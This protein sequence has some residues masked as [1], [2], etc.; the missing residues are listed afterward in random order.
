LDNFPEEKREPLGR[1]NRLMSM[2]VASTQGNDVLRNAYRTTFQ[3][4]SNKLDALQRL[5]SSGTPDG[6][7][8]EMARLE[9]EQ[10]RLAHSSAR[11]RLAGELL[12]P[13]L[14]APS[15]TGE[16]H[17]GHDIEDNVRATARL[18]WELAG[19]PEGSAERDWTRAEQ[20]VH[21]ATSS[22]C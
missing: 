17:I 2:K 4:Y 1:V 15:K 3:E 16:H 11:D 21:A 13:P 22:G 5:M 8:M 12:R 20:L 14:P 19:R 9:V 6:T 18:L 10:A 7:R